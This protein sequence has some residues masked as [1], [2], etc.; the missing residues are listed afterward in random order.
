MVDIP[1]PVSILMYYNSAS[2]VLLVYDLNLNITSFTDFS[3]NFLLLGSQ[4]VDLVSLYFHLYF[5][6]FLIYFS[7]F[8]FLELWG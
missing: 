1:G 2:S 4:K 7:S 5:I 6:L 3:S 8:L